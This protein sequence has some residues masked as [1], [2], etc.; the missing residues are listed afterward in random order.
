MNHD[1]D[2]SKYPLSLF[3]EISRMSFVSTGRE[4]VI[5]MLTGMALWVLPLIRL[6]MN[7]KPSRVSAWCQLTLL[8]CLQMKIIAFD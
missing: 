2:F 1:H 5:L 3:K 6:E 7:L 4:G 8:M